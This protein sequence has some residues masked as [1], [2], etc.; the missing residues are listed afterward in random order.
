MPDRG[1]EAT[2]APIPLP[3]AAP[4]P[5]QPNISCTRGLP[6]WL[7]RNNVSL[8]FTSY[9]T[10]RLYLVG[11]DTN[12]RVSFHERFLAR[13]MGLWADPQRILVST[14]FQVWRF[15]NVLAGPYSGTGPD[16]HY[17][18]RVAHPQAV[19]EPPRRVWHRQ[20]LGDD[21]VAG[22]VH[23]APT[24]CAAAAPAIHHIAV[25]RCRHVG[26]SAIFHRKAIE[27][28]PIF[29]RKLG[30][31]GRLPEHAKGVRGAQ[32]GE[33]GEHC[34]DEHDAAIGHD[35]DVVD[36]KVAGSV[37]SRREAKA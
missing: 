9:Q 32:R 25:A 14:I 29:R 16:R 34:I 35:A 36:V 33:T 19:V 15:E 17:V 12:G 3:Q 27:V 37:Q 21:G 1:K 31:E 5:H 11:V 10:G 8:A 28:A 7:L 23:D 13:A 4:A 30:Y 24:F 20:L 22:H 6:D 26:R 2:G 18:P